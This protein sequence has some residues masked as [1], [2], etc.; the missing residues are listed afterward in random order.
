MPAPERWEHGSSFALPSI[1]DLPGGGQWPLPDPIGFYGSGRRA[2]IEI[3]HDSAVS[4][5]TVWLPNYYCPEVINAVEQKSSYSIRYYKENIGP[6]STNL[7]ELDVKPQDI[8][9][10]QNLFG[11]RTHSPITPNCIVVE[12]HTHDPL[13]HWAFNTTADYAFASLRKTIPVPDGATV[14]T[15]TGRP[16][17]RNH[18]TPLELIHAIANQVEAMMMKR[19]YFNSNENVRQGMHQTLDNSFYHIDNG[20]APG[21][22]SPLSKLLL[23]TYPLFYWK[24]MR[25]RN[26]DYLLHRLEIPGC[27]ILEPLSSQ[28]TPFALVCVFDSMVIRN[29]LLEQLIERRIFPSVLWQW[30]GQCWGQDE[31]LFSSNHLVFRCEFRYEY[32]DLKRLADAIVEEL[33][34]I[35]VPK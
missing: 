16:T 29:K 14:W 1:S 10:V 33:N 15:G 6:E 24:E 17:L 3:I 11:L 28:A 4:G 34:A 20:A 2:L 5:S 8:L 12:D 31:H 23:Y 13:S 32:S 7:S 27:N 35:E 30:E 26:F 22:M 9:I 18:D 25:A 21:T 19:E